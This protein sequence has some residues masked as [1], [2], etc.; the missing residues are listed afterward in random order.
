MKHSIDLK[1]AKSADKIDS[2]CNEVNL[3]SFSQSIESLEKETSFNEPKNGPSL[4]LKHNVSKKESNSDQV[5][6]SKSTSFLAPPIKPVDS[7]DAKYI[8]YLKCGIGNYFSSSPNLLNNQNNKSTNSLLASTPNLFQ[9][10]RKSHYDCN[11]NQS[12]LIVSPTLVKH[13]P[14]IHH[15]SPSASA[16]F[17]PAIQVKNVH[18]NYRDQYIKTKN[19]L[20]NVNLTCSIGTIYG[21]L[22]PSGCG[23]TT[24]IKLMLGKFRPLSGEI[25]AF[26]YDVESKY[27]VW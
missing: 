2:Y 23:K 12:K 17:P 9:N 20:K 1:T 4:L 26:G 22:G 11:E 13:H 21:L 15:D 25:K 10:S 24:L 14:V 3:S 8:P 5:E 7:T 27:R 18:F 6:K 16:S 19:V